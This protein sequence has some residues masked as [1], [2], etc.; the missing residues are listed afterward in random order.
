MVS[1]ID[2]GSAGSFPANLT[3]VSGTLFFSATNGVTGVELWQSNGTAA[4]TVL[5]KKINPAM[6]APLPTSSRT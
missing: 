1:D 3:N 2:P 4:G 6:L 5:V